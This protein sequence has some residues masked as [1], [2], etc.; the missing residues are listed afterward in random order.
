VHTGFWWGNLREGERFED[1]GLRRKDNI[2][3]D[4]REVE[5]G[6]VLYRFGSGYGQVEGSCECG[7]EPSSSIKCGKFPD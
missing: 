2:K 7:N 6:H 4:F 3:M 1:P 5:W